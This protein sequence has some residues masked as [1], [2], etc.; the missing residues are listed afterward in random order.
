MVGMQIGTPIMEISVDVPQELELNPPY[1]TAI[2]S[3]AY[4]P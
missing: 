3:S 2:H 4:I 1:D